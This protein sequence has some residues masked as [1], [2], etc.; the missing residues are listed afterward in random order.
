MESEY[1]IPTL[2]TE[3]K[4]ETDTYTEGENWLIRGVVSNNDM[5]SGFGAK[6]S[7]FSTLEPP[8]LENKP[9]RSRI[10]AG[11]YKI[12]PRRYNKGGYDS[13][14]I[15][16]VPGRSLILFHAG[17]VPRNTRGAC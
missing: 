11:T 7:I 4:A 2:E 3:R 15:V 17:N 8:W 5:V 16:G 9:N 1:G 14:E 12:K 6:T 10:P 13:F